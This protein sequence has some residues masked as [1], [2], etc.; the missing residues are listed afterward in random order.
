MSD[1]IAVTGPATGGRGVAAV[2]SAQSLIDRGTLYFDLSLDRKQTGEQTL[3]DYAEQRG[4]ARGLSLHL[5]PEQGVRLRQ[6]Q[7]GSLH[8]L[9]LT[10]RIPADRRRLR[11]AYAWAAPD[12]RCRL[13]LETAS[14]EGLAS[15]DGFGPL[16]LP[17]E[18]IPSLFGP[19]AD[20]HP[21]VQWMGLAHGAVPG[22]MGAALGSG[23]FVLTPAGQVRA[24]RLKVGDRVVT[25]DRGARPLR[26]V[27][28]QTMP[29]FGSL[30][31]VRLRAPYFGAC[32]DL[33]VAPNAHVLMRGAEV[34]YLFGED[35]VLV[36]AR[37]LTGGNL[38]MP[39][40]RRALV[41]FVALG[42]ERQEVIFVDGCG[43]GTVPLGPR[44]RLARRVL[45]GYEVVP[46]LAMRDRARNPSA[47]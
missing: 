44:A 16:P 43:V 35:E 39:E 10:C 22:G 5:D 20:L 42:F 7:G 19:L 41:G 37:L 15:V 9:D 17:T 26:W 32:A 38:A 25:A 28:A 36:Q 29:G 30:T 18:D 21:S 3:I 13:T 33:V 27:R 40:T 11:L 47:A 6:R 31:P 45:Q 23:S 4:W 8:G 34:E 14:G 2:P 12:R 24:D 46:L 1:W